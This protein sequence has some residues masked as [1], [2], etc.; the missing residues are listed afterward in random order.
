VIRVNLTR[1][2]E[3]ARQSSGR[4][5]GRLLAS[6]PKRR[7]TLAHLVAVAAIGLVMAIDTRGPAPAP[8]FVGLVIVSGF[9]LLHVV[10][11]GKVLAPSTLA[12]DAVGTAVVIG[13][14]GAPSSP[15]FLL[16]IAGVWWAAHVPRRHTGLL[17][18]AAFTLA[19]TILVIPSALRDQVFVLALEDMAMVVIVG[20]LSDWFVRV[21]RRAIELSE[22]LERAPSGAAE[23]ELRAGLTRALGVTDVPVDIVLAAA[24]AGL[25]VTQA[26]ILAY[27]SMGLTNQEIADATKVSEATVRYRLTRLY[28]ALDVHGRR[29]AVDR[30]HE[31]GLIA[32]ESPIPR[33]DPT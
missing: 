5:S 26:E 23:L 32:S 19:Y 16:A 17:Y 7:I 30:A 11:A 2:I 22:A 13:G 18:A 10:S 4:F 31:T 28:R 14:T 8:L 33:R 25:T 24:R 3:T 27:L 29:E 9:A 6:E 20:L 21:D 15:L 12:L 1:L